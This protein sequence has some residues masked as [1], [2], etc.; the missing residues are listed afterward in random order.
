MAHRNG[1]ARP[2]TTCDDRRAMR[3]ER[4]PREEQRYATKLVLAAAAFGAAI[5]PTSVHG[6]GHALVVRVADPPAIAYDV[7]ALG[8]ATHPVRVALQNPGARPLAISP[9]TFRFLPFRDGVAF[10][11]EDPSSIA[12]RWPATLV[13]GGSFVASRGVTCSTPL[14]GRYDVEVRARP[15]GA[16]DGA[17]RTYA[18]FS[19]HIEPGANPPVALPWAPGLFVAASTTKE[20]RPGNDPNAVRLV[21]A[22]INGA[23]T[24]TTLAPLH[25]TTH[26]TRRGSRLPPCG[27]RGFDFAFGGELAAGRAR[28][29][30]A[31]LGCALTADA[32]YDV[33]VHVSNAAGA[34]VRA[35][36][37]A[38]RVGVLPPP[39]P[40]PEEM[41][42]GQ[43]RLIGGM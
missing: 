35:G 33:E 6:Q 3:A 29:L 27:E 15:R 37:Y 9:L 16:A 42:S 4:P 41:T 13:P 43:G 24:T 21:L 39:P 7:T 34:K 38:V 30:A 32:V 14:P 31:P 18:T 23:K 40:R 25:A 12:E 36:L 5:A 28:S 8:T 26:V 19:L 10:V 17:E 11:C 2:E 20:I 22:T 1:Q